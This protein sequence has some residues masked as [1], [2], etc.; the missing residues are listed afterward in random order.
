MR[1]IFIIFLMQTI[2][3]NAFASAKEPNRLKT[4]VCII[5]AGSGGIGAAL[6]ASRAGAK[7]VLIEKQGRVGGTS[8]LAFVNNWEPGPGCSFARE[9]YERMRATSEAIEISKGVHGYQNEEPYGICV[10]DP[11]ASY[12]Q[13]LRRSDLTSASGVIFGFEKFDETVRGMLEETGNCKILLSTSFTRALSKYKKVKTIEAVSSTGE[14]YE[15]SAKVF[16]D[17][18][19]G[20]VVCRNLGCETMLGAEAKAK[21]NE[22][23][24]PE[25]S[26]DDLNAISLCYRI[27]KSDHPKQGQ[28]APEG[29]FNYRLVAVSYDIPGEGDTKSINP[30][31]IMDGNELIKLGYDGAYQMAR[32]IIDDHW[33]KLQYYPHF[34][35]Y[36]FD[37]YA[38]MLGIRESFRV[39]GEYVLNQHDLLTGYKMQSQKDIIA[40]AD[41][42][43]DVHGRN[44]SLSTLPEA[45]GIPYRCLIPKG[46]SNLLVACRGASFSH[47]AASSCRLSRTMIALGHAAGFAASVAS[48]ENIPVLEVPVERVQAEMNLKLRPKENMSS[49]PEPIKTTIGKK[50]NSYLCSDNGKG[51]I[52]ILS[53]EGKIIWDYP[54]SECQ[55]LSQLPNGN[56]LFT[57]YITVKGKT[58]GGVCEITHDKQKIFHYEIDGEVHSCQRLDNGNTLLTDNNNGRLIEVSPQGKV[59]KT[60]VL[61]TKVRGHSAIRMIRQLDNGNYLVCQEQ[62]QLVVEYDTKGEVVNSFKS[63]GKCFGAIRLKNGNTLISDGSACSVREINQNGKEVWKISKE[64]FPEL[65]LNWIT[66]IQELPSGNLL[67]CNWLGHGKYGEGIPLFEVTKEK[68]VVWY[69]TDNFSTESISNI[70]LIKG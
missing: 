6:A 15:I 26:N 29:T 38:P 42:P 45:Y 68:K 37:C 11:T 47:L 65:K 35:G 40:L 9:I 7:V 31:G 20:A 25:K 62:D 50:R 44:T 28:P 60:L 41:H 13:T 24:A 58:R 70:C 53:S 46:W 19:G 12:N 52:Y 22:P 48:K 36:E 2:L 1:F 16:I 54:V 39:V 33:A 18:T 32:K 17:C 23:S 34:Q 21:F 59:V 69:F 67:I 63:P 51:K 56:I 57:Y 43:M 3:P 8:T 64:D 14:K 10:I 55:D 66:G 4:D 30:L 27:R 49:D 61:K 5:G